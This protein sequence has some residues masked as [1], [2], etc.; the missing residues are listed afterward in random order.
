[1]RELLGCSLL[2]IRYLTPRDQ[3]GKRDRLGRTFADEEQM[4]PA[5]SARYAEAEN[6]RSGYAAS[7][8][9]RTAIRIDGIYA[10]EDVRWALRAPQCLFDRGRRIPVQML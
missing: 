9:M 5:L 3:S 2:F 7:L 1:M 8:F 4:I 10:G 6:H